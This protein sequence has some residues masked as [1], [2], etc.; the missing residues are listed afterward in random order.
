MK[1]KYLITSALPYINGIKHL[2]NLVGSMLPADVYARFQR[3]K[4]ND[5][6]FICGTDE[7]GSP[8]E[9]S[10]KK[11]GMPVADFCAHLYEVQKKIYEAF[12]LSFDHFGR[13]SRPQNHELT[14]HFAKKL[15]ENGLIEERA[16][17]QF[18]SVDDGRFLSDRFIEGTCPYCGYTKARGDQCE[19]CTKVLDPTDLKN[20]RSAISGSE[21]LE[22]RE[23]N[24]LFLLQSKV[25]GEVKEWLSKKKNWPHGVIAIGNKWIDEGIQDRC[26]TRDL[27]WGVP[28]PKKGFEGKVFYVWFDAPIGYIAATKEWSDIDPAHRDWKSW[29][30]NSED[31]VYHVQFMAKDNVPFH[32]VSFPSTLLGSKEPWKTADYI[33]GFNWLTY[34]GG[35]FSTSQGR[36]IFTDEALKLYPSDY[37]RYYLM[38]QAPESADSDFSWEGLATAVN[39]DM[40]DLLGNQYQRVSKLVDTYFESKVPTAGPRTETETKLV[41]R[42]SGAFKEYEESLDSMQFRK[43]TQSLRELWKIGNEYL[44]QSAPWKEAK[45][46]K[47]KAGAT[48][49][50]AVNLL[51]FYSIVSAPMIPAISGKISA[52]LGLSPEEAKWP[53]DIAKELEAIND[54]RQVRPTGILVN[55][56]KPEDVVAFRSK[57]GDENIESTSKGKEF[58]LSAE[59]V[60]KMVQKKTLSDEGLSL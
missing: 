57:Y 7:H 8:A 30:L 34:Y 46:N 42:L 12:E 29:W 14:Q 18:Y 31:S 32:T 40:A 4:G 60:Q 53:T 23:S 49:N 16:I 21:N 9:I 35:K 13:T 51:R 10:A 19:S 3:A 55:K 6:L 20:P 1:K 54:H 11:A 15:E 47:E 17:K 2:G 43:A 52:G 39:K 50:V 41:E 25:A 5:V 38:S 28:V 22:L 26:I 27:E 48:L 56:I 33:K 44:E 58:N 36:G 37:W 24:H 45:V 59:A